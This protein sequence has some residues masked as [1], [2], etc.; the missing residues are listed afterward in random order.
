MLSGGAAVVIAGTSTTGSCACGFGADA[1]GLAFTVQIATSSKPKKRP[2]PFTLA[3]NSRQQRDL[4]LLATAAFVRPAWLQQ[5]VAG[6]PS[7]VSFLAP[8]GDSV[9]GEGSASVAAAAELREHSETRSETGDNAAKT[10]GKGVWRA[11]SFGRKKKAPV[12]DQSRG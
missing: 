12:P 10:K 5:A 7:S 4:I 6:S 11:L 1:E 8:A 9:Q 2:P 3:V